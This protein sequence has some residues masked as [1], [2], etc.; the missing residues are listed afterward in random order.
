MC[1]CTDMIVYF[2]S[3]VFIH[4]ITIN[5]I[6]FHVFSDQ[7]IIAVTSKYIIVNSTQIRV[8]YFTM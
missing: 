6:L 8:R 1:P 3:M 2:F 5:K 4:L 7:F